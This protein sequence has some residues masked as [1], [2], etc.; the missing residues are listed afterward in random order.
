MDVG[1]EAGVGPSGHRDEEAVRP[2]VR[3]DVERAALDRQRHVIPIAAIA[4][5]ARA[6]VAA[7]ASAVDARA[8]HVADAPD[9]VTDQ[10]A[11]DGHAVLDRRDVAAVQISD[12][13][14][15]RVVD[16]RDAVAASIDEPEGAVA[17]WQPEAETIGIAIDLGVGCA[18][19][20]T[21]AADRQ[22]SRRASDY[23]ASAVD[24]RDAG[25]AVIQERPVPVA[26]R[27]AEG[28]VVGVLRDVAAAREPDGAAIDVEVAAGGDVALSVESAAE[29]ADPTDLQRAAIDREA[30]R[31]DMH[32]A[33][34]R[35]EQQ[36]VV[37]AEIVA[38]GDIEPEPAAA[39]AAQVEH[40]AGVVG[41]ATDEAG[42]LVR[43]AVVGRSAAE[44][45]LGVQRLSAGSAT[46]APQPAA[47]DDR[48]PGEVG[49][50]PDRQVA[51]EASRAIDR[52]AAG[53]V[54]AAGTVAGDR[55]VGVE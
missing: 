28:A 37:L 3:R 49:R 20:A 25:V 34:K 2:V 12:V 53:N 31:A 15:A 24:M 8:A 10:R 6:D 41:E 54:R 26:G 42:A 30:V 11:V 52:Q 1:F 50:A 14:V 39:L 32:R 29:I 40:H 22:I 35:V 7:A 48:L 19:E 4:L 5:K 23:A 36:R 46:V 17:A 27:Q 16:M 45:L 47:M 51:V 9:P 43:A 33:A 38:I 13:E 21:A 18:K 44:V 55:R